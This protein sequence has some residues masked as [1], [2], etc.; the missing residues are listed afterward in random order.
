[1]NTFPTGEQI[2]AQNDYVPLERM[3]ENPAPSVETIVE[4]ARKKLEEQRRLK[5]IVEELVKQVLKVQ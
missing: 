3:V 5:V 4:L 2:L 1:M